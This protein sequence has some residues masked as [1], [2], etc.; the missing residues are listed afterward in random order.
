M[1]ASVALQLH[2]LQLFAPVLAEAV[3]AAIV[4]SVV[5]VFLSV[6][7]VWAAIVVPVVVVISVEAV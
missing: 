7:A 3:R 4:V 2:L 1:Y 5:V 6:E